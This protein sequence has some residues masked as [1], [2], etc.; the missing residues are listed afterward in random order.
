MRDCDDDILA[1]LRDARARGPLSGVM[2]SFTGDAA[3]AAQ[4]VEMGLYISFA[5]M[6]TFKK[7]DALRSCAASVRADRLLIESDAPYLSP[8]PVRGQR[9]N[10]PAHLVHTAACLADVRGVSVEQLAEQTSENARRLF[11]F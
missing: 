6:V 5:G 7:S 2:H 3:L 10:E 8:H 1:M 9:R 11:R 4:C